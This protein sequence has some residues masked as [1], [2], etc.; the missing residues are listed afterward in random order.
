MTC[1]VQCIEIYRKFTKEKEERIPVPTDR[2]ESIPPIAQH[3]A[4]SFALYTIITKSSTGSY[5]RC[6]LSDLYGT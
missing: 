5:E 4:S 2:K 3:E 6:S 1:Q